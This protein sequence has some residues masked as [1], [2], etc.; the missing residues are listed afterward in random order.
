[1]PKPQTV[2]NVAV[3]LLLL[4]ISFLAAYL[5]LDA[6][7]H[8]KLASMFFMLAIPCDGAFAVAIVFWVYCSTWAHEPERPRM[9]MPGPPPG[10]QK[11]PAPK[12]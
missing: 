2:R 3:F 10:A 4:G 9:P 5:Y 7:G 6:H 12:P 1:M 8:P 11:P